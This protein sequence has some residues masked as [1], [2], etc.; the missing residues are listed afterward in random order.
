MKKLISLLVLVLV[1]G[2]ITGCARALKTC[3]AA[4]LDGATVCYDEKLEQ[5]A[6]ESDAVLVVNV[7]NDGLGNAVVA[8]WDAAHP[9]FA[10]KL[11]FVNTGS[12]GAPD[13]ITTDTTAFPDVSM[14]IDGE[15][16][17]NVTAL[18]PI[19]AV[20]ANIIKANAVESFYNAGNSTAVT[21]YAPVTYDGMAFIW[22]ETMLTA[23]GLSVADADKDNLP[24]AFD[25]WEEIFALGTAWK[26]SRP[27]YLD[28][29]VKTVFPLSLAEVWS[30]YM[31]VSSSGWQI[32]PDGDATKPGYD[33]AKFKASFDFLLDA[34][35]AAIDTNDLG[36]TLA[37]ENMGWRWGDMFNNQSAPFGLVGT[38]DDPIAA[39][40]TNNAVY[41]ISALPTYKGVRL[42]PFVK[43]KGWVINGYTKYQ[44]AATELLRL[45]Y[46]Q[47]G[48]QALVDS[49]AYAPSLI[50]GSALTPT[51]DANSV[52]SQFMSA[53]VYNH[54]EPFYTMPNNKTKKG[55]DSVYY[56]FMGATLASIWNGTKTV[57]EAV[58]ELISLSDA[59]IAVDNVA[60]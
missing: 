42:T 48:F 26:T 21:V 55:M 57:D 36:E 13:K 50:D 34:K 14:A 1:A 2:S 54:P 9:E 47:D 3:D 28:M 37:A 19:D 59:A 15:V 38:W 45:I 60:Q 4:N 6:V 10:G 25:T 32:F 43:T 53:L 27:T 58:A 39:G 35:A 20:L 5:Y 12:Q 18:L 7:D 51:L 11:T 40:E 29:P 56:S 46:S 23:L 22:N 41:H 44:S 31:V 33:D 17:R 30:A 52:Q 16:S 24:D 49:S 8:L